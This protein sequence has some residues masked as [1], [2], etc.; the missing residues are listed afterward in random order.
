MKVI[1]LASGSKGNSTYIEY[2][3]TK[4]LIDIGISCLSLERK[5]N[6]YGVSCDELDAILI[7][8]THTDHVS[9]LK[10]FNKKH[11]V[12]V[13]MSELMK[14]DIDYDVDNIEYINEP[15]IYIKEMLIKVIKM[16]I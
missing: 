7:T 6:S 16:D 9:G 3:N 2:N 5:L 10:T 15:I 1:V 13:Y 8:H 12:P 4:I 14:D 11:K